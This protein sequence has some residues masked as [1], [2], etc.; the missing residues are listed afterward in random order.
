M[1]TFVKTESCRACGGGY[2]TNLLD[3]GTQY[4]IDF[5]KDRNSEN[6]GQAPLELML[7]NSC[8]LVQLRHTVSADTMFRKFWYRSGTNE[9]MVKQLENI[10]L[11]AMKRA[12]LDSGSK[13]LDIGANDGTL[14]SFYPKNFGI[15]RYAVDP[16][17]QFV[18]EAM[19]AG[20]CERYTPDYFSADLFKGEQFKII[21][22]IAMFYDLDNPLKFL[23]DIKAVLHPEGVVVIQQNYLMSML[24]LGTVDN[25]S[26]E[27]LC[28]YSLTSLTSLLK[29]AG[30][31]VSDV[32]RN[33]INGGSFRV[34]VRH[35]NYQPPIAISGG[36]VK[37]TDQEGLVGPQH[38]NAMLESEQVL[39]S[40]SIYGEFVNEWERKKQ[41]LRNYIVKNVRAQLPVYAYGASTR[42]NTI[43]QALNLPEGA[44]SG[45][46]ERA[47]SKIGLMMVGSWVP[48]V[49][50]EEARRKCKR[51]FVLPYHFGKAIVEREDAWLSQGGDLLFPLPTP[52]RVYKV[53]NAV[54]HYH[55][56]GDV[57]R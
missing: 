46:A 22:C 28:Y 54:R 23:E 16:A 2:F 55:L 15:S 24:K 27:H 52:T 21:T 38:I 48:I 29:K 4:I 57:T 50:E 3:L 5:V 45:C 17:G 35:D 1:S 40:L 18:N 47:E 56:T 34:Y 37:D 49:S 7:C 30:L 31:R 41:I 42:G 26:H 32:E 43:L 44:L 36:S 33:D 14:L 13:V 25:I 53:G 6:R 39:K 9:A 8:H 19:A 20:R 10:A 12:P 51:F 11:S